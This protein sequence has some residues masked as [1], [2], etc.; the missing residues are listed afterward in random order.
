MTIKE[1]LNKGILKLKE[2]N[3]D[4]AVAKSR[5][6]LS[7]LL[8]KDK[9]YLITNDSEKVSKEV[10]TVFTECIKELTNGIPMQYITNKKEFMKMNFYVDS[11]VLIPREDT[12]ILV[13]EVISLSK[14]Y[15][16][17]IE[18]LEMCTGSG[19]ICISLAKNVEKCTITAS[20]ISKQAL[21]VANKNAKAHKVQDKI[22]FICSDLY[23]DIPSNKYDIIVV[24]PPYIKTTE[25]SSLP[26]DVQHEPIIA[27]DGGSDG[28][29]FYKRII[30][31]L[32]KYIKKGGYLCLEI[33]YNQKEEV[34]GLLKMKEY[35]DIVTKKDLNGNDRVI[36]VKV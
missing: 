3:V 34:M 26:S 24:N 7:H 36:I 15:I 30:K 33:G 32:N 27:L 28:L 4:S 25:I 12:E 10:N 5:I 18:I 17:D 2:N 21:K 14:N 19:A 13:E 23:N 31:G 9:G 11:H 1:T 20:D 22:E 8:E 29:E 35:K 16:K 6:I